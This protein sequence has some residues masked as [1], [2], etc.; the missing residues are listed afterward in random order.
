MTD[1][2]A[3]GQRVLEIVQLLAA[4]KAGLSLG[5]CFCSGFQVVSIQGEVLFHWIF[6]ILYVKASASKIHYL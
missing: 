6:F 5:F 4:I 1:L 3:K 2:R